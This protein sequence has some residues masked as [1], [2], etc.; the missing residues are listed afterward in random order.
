[1]ASG[2]CISWEAFSVEPGGSA[3]EVVDGFIEL[4]EFVGGAGFECQ[5]GLFVEFEGLHVLQGDIEG[6]PEASGY[7]LVD[8]EHAADED[9]E[10]ADLDEEDTFEKVVV[11]DEAAADDELVELSADRYA[12]GYFAEWFFFPVSVAEAGGGI[13]SIFC[14]LVGW[15]EE[16]VFVHFGPGGEF[17]AGMDLVDVFADLVQLGF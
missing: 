14:L 15:G 2:V 17:V 10:D 16:D 13:N 12:S 7:F 11:L 1:M 4:V 3:E 9:E 6:L 8:P 5:V